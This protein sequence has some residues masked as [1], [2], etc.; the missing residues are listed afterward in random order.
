MKT[1]DKKDMR[2]NAIQDQIARRAYE[3]WEQD[4]YRHGSHA[5]HWEDAERQ[6]FGTVPTAENPEYSSLATRD[7]TT[8]ENAGKNEPVKALPATV[9]KKSS[10]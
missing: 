7:L 3:L 10:H 4:G 5:K 2:E 1:S 6:L 8:M 9:T